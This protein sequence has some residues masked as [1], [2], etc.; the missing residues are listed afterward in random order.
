MRQALQSAGDRDESMVIAFGAKHRAIERPLSN[1]HD[2]APLSSVVDASRTN[3]AGAIRLALAALPTDRLR[4]IVLLSDGN[5]NLGLV[6]PIRVSIAASANVPNL[7]GTA[8]SESSPKL[9]VRSL[10]TPSFIREGENFSYEGWR[11]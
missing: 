4:K 6:L 8:R 5:E 1:S 9:L 7:G 2:I 3:L 10:E 11:L